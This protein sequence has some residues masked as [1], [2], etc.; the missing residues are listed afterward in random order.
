MVEIYLIYGL[1]FILLGAAALLQPRDS[2]ALPISRH[3]WLL[4]LFGLLHGGKEIYD[5]WVFGTGAS[6]PAVGWTGV[7]LLITS[8]LPLFEFGRRTTADWLSARTLPWWAPTSAWVYGPVLL[9]LLLTFVVTTDRAAGLDAVAR[10]ILAFPGAVLA[11][12]TLRRA[13]RESSVAKHV[14][15]FSFVAY[16]I[17]GG[18]ITGR[19]AEFPTWLPTSA[20]FLDATGIPVQ[21]LRASCAFAAMLSLSILVRS[22]ARMAVARVRESAIRFQNLAESLERRIEKRTSALRESEERL[23]GFV[24]AAS[25]WLWETDEQ[26][27]FTYMSQDADN[28]KSNSSAVNLGTTRFDWRLPEDKD[29]EKWRHHKADLDSARPFKNFE[30]P[31]RNPDGSVRHIRING[32]PVFAEGGKFVGYRGT[33]SDVTEQK[34]DEQARLALIEDKEHEIQ[35]RQLAEIERDQ[36][37]ARLSEAIES[38]S[39]GFAVWGADDRLVMCNS[40]YLEVFRQLSDILVPGMTFEDFLRMAVERGVYDLGDQTLEAFIESRMEEHRNPA[41][42]FERKLGNEQWVRISKRRTESGGIVGIWT[43]V[44]ERR[45]AEETI[46]DLAMSDSLTGLANRYRFH[47]DI[48]RA[49]VDAKRQ[50]DRVA[51]LML[52]LDKLKNVND[53]FGHSVGDIL[54]KQVAGRLV[55]CAR[56]T[57]TVAR[58]GGDEFAVVMTH[59]DDVEAPAHLAE[60]IIESM[61]KSFD[62]GEHAVEIGTSIGISVYPDDDEDVEPLIRKADSALYQA[63]AEGRGNFKLYD[64]VI[65]DAVLATKR[66]ERDLRLAIDR[67]EFVLH[68]QPQIDIATRQVTGAEALIRWQ[69]PERGLLSPG[70]FIGIAESSDLIVEIGRRVLQKACQQA[71][72]WQADPL[73][74]PLLVAVNISPRQ[75]KNDDLVA[76]VE[77][78]LRETGLAAGSLELEIT[79]G[80]MMEDFEQASETLSH[81]SKLGVKIAIDDFGTGYSSLAYLKRF[82][83]QRLKIDQSFVRGLTTD[84]D[85]TAIVRAVIGLGHSLRLNVIAEGVETDVELDI[86]AGLGCQEAQGYL[87]CRPVAAEDFKAW[88]AARHEALAVE[89]DTVPA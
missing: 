69:H 10:Y 24:D 81:L 34:R 8:F 23:T 51:L 53:E 44:T 72:K 9:S 14:L 7:S 55:A 39:E 68:Y 63:K 58:L 29:D 41:D 85:D 64:A 66:I 37:M 78:T 87:F 25:D 19:V 89:A 73:V 71:E 27:R 12:L 60:R 47:A 56:E 16:A 17:L 65:H 32:R 46:R 48:E 54:L 49:L 15:W 62:L 86:L 40:R 28:V 59:M 26:H 6:G 57:D 35:A 31:I 20:A 61:A 22:E 45:K 76:L 83:V 43:D 13:F 38:I 80:T 21:V 2:E 75:F 33:G 42:A 30:F 50:N 70:D 74:P 5:A 52:D 77:D 67:D 88:I 4:G 84:N 11:G 3:F 79:E 18:L 82:P 36:A 1:S